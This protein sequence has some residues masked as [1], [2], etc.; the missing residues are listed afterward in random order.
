M[1]GCWHTH[2]GSMHHGK[3]ATHVCPI[4]KKMI[5]I[6]SLSEA[7]HLYMNN[8]I[9]EWVAPIFVLAINLFINS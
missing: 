5:Q 2:G 4:C 3:S 1:H 8:L 9:D 7:L 6:I